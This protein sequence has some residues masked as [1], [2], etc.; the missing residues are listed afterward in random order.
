LH[1]T[2][3]KEWLL[4]IYISNYQGRISNNVKSIILFLMFID[5]RCDCIFVVKCSNNK[6]I[7]KF[8]FI[9]AFPKADTL[10]NCMKIYFP[11]VSFSTIET[12]NKKWQNNNNEIKEHS[13]VS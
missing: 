9:S 12:S 11:E 13:N 4:A 7:I 1:F 2:A 3:I 6:N 10:A 8:V 5:L